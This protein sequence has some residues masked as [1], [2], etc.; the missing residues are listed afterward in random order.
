MVEGVGMRSERKAGADQSGPHEERQ[1]ISILFYHGSLGGVGVCGM[2][3]RNRR[4]GGGDG[5]QVVDLRV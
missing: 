1:R 3:R 4:R 2:G 5:R